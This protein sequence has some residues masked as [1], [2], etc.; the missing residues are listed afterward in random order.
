MTRLLGAGRATFRAFEVPNY[1]PYFAGQ[2]I[3]LSGTWMQIRA[4]RR[5]PAPGRVLMPADEV[6]CFRNGVPYARARRSMT[7]HRK[8]LPYARA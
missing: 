1:R 3:S 5:R 8:G 2:A 6:L 7:A 4:P